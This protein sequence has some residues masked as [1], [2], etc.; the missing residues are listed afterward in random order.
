MDISNYII[1]LD[2]YKNRK[3]NNM[4]TFDNIC[5]T[6]EDVCATTGCYPEEFEITSRIYGHLNG[7]I[8]DIAFRNM[9]KLIESKLNASLTS[10]YDVVMTTAGL[11]AKYGKNDPEDMIKDVI[12]NDP[13]TIVLW[14]DG[15]KTVVKTQEDC[16]FDPYVGLAMAFSKKMFGNKGSYFNVFKKY[17]EPYEDKKKKEFESVLKGIYNEIASKFLIPLSML[18]GADINGEPK[19][20][21][22]K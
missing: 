15:T 22:D 8:H 14:K 1:A 17:C 3:D 4:K 5:W 20:K 7:N 16:E 18:T 12:F 11:N 13:A 10:T 19:P 9:P 21:D 6:A 2:Y